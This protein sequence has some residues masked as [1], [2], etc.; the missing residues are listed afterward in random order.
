MKTP[1]H[2]VREYDVRGLVEED[3]SDDL[4]RALG[5]AFATFIAASRA[6]ATRSRSAGTCGL[7]AGSATG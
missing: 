4:V 5:R 6:P 3:L 7:P 1:A 2:I